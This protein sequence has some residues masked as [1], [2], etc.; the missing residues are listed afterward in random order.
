MPANHNWD[1]YSVLSELTRWKQSG[2]WQPWEWEHPP[3]QLGVEYRTTERWNGKAVYAKAFDFG[4]LPNATEKQVEFCA[5]GATAVCDLKLHLSDGYL[6]SSGY[7]IDKMAQI[8]NGLNLGNTPTKV[9]VHTEG[10]YSNLTAYATI[11]YTKD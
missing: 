6:L 9:R 11:K 1:D 5:E 7:G 3:M 8:S 4:A 10:N 2:V